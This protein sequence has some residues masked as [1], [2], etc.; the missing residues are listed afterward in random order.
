MSLKKHD[1]VEIEYTGRLKE[2]NIIFDT[3]DEKTAKENDIH[4]KNM[5]YG[6]VIVCLGEKQII[7]GLDD[8]LIGKEKGKY[9]IELKPEDAFGKKDAKL[10]KLVPM[11]SFRKENINPMP[12]LQVSIDGLLGIVRTATGGRVIVDFNHPLSGKDIIYDVN[13]KRIVTD[14]KEKVK[15]YIELQ[16]GLKDIKVDV[17]DKKADIKTKKELP[18]QARDIL[19][20]KLKELVKLD[21]IKFSVE[22]SEKQLKDNK[23]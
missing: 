13:V 6:P 18:E 22:G 7:K 9:T 20:K 23:L 16:T 12:G 14:D 11:S 2:G 3:T 19:I 1:F 10:L 21:D 8:N 4:N 5:V 17:K 15:G